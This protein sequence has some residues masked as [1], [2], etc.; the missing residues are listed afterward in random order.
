MNIEQE[1][2]SDLGVFVRAGVANGDVEPYEFTDINRTVAVGLALK[3]T[4]WSRP[5]DT[6]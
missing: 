1:I 3:G 4:R 2:T 6:V 5:D